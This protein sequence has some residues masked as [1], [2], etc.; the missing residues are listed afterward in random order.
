[1]KSGSRYIA[2]Q[3]DVTLADGQQ[4]TDIIL[5]GY[6]QSGHSTVYERTGRNTWRVVVYSLGNEHFLGNDS[7]QVSINVNGNEGV[8]AIENILFVTDGFIENR[9]PSIYGN[10]TGIDDL[11]FT[12]SRYDCP[13]Y[14]LQ[15]RKVTNKRKGPYI[16]NGKK[17]LVK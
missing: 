17:A 8:V 14:D 10:A 3:F 12:D 4:P 6:R 5:N 11:Q 7:E 2:A 13:V 1:M 15:G 9:F 16:V